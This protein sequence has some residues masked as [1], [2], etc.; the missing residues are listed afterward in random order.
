MVKYSLFF[1]KFI[2]GVK[3]HYFLQSFFQ[4]IICTTLV[5][6]LGACSKN[7]DEVV[8]DTGPVKELPA[9]LLN[10]FRAVFMDAQGKIQDSVLIKE[11]THCMTALPFLVH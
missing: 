7:K 6:T 9:L 11:K 8:K 10:Q 1:Y 5:F 3:M 2:K 4:T